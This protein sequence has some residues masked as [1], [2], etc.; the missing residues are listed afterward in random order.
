MYIREYRGQYLKE[1][2][3]K[4]TGNTKINGNQNIEP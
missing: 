1:I 3:N 2:F 4:V